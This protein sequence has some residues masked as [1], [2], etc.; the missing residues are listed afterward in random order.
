MHVTIKTVEHFAVYH[1]VSFCKFLNCDTIDYARKYAAMSQFRN[2]QKDAAAHGTQQLFET[3][4]A[5]VFDVIKG[6]KDS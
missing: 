5:I 1:A 2:L 4:A 6:F 3:S